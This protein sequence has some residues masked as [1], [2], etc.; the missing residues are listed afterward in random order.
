MKKRIEAAIRILDPNSDAAWRS[1]IQALVLDRLKLLSAEEENPSP[2]PANS[3]NLLPGIPF[4]PE[5]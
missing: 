1:M 2:D 3:G 4:P 5:F